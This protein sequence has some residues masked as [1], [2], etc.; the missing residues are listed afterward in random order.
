MWSHKEGGLSTQVNYREKCTFGGLKGRSLNAGGLK[1]RFDCLLLLTN[2]SE[3]CSDE[4]QTI[5]MKQFC[6]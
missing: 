5:H 3:S 4:K 6:K 1:D 2:R